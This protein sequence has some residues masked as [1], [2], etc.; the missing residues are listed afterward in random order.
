MLPP[1]PPP[2][3]FRA[4]IYRPGRNPL[5]FFTDLARQYGDVVYLKLGGERLFVISDP[6][7]I[8]DVLVTRQASFMKG[9]GLERA[10]RLLGQGLLTS[11]GALHRQQRRLLQPAFHRDRIATY[12]ATMTGYADRVQCGWK[13]GQTFDVAREMQRL[14]LLIV[15]KT[16]FDTD[17]EAEAGEVGDAMNGV[18][19]SFWLL[20][21]PFSRAL[22]H[23]PLPRIRRGQRARAKLDAMI[24]R[25]IHDRRAS[26]EDRGDL[27]SML[28]TAQDEEQRGGMSD[29]QVRDEAMTIFLAGHETTANALMWTWYLLSQSPEV[30]A[31]LHQEIDRVIGD[32]LPTLSDIPALPYVE[33]VVTESMRLYPPAWIIGRRALEE[34]QLG[35]YT[36]PTRSIVIMSPFIV[37]RDPRHFPDPECFRPER[38]TPE[39]KAKLAPFAYFPFGGGARRCIGESFAWMELALVLST[40]ARRWRLRLVPGHPIVPHPLVTLRSKYGMKMTATRR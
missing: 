11:E 35:D 37:H 2:S 25:M 12:A 39:F 31:R 19:E 33:Q 32:R 16:L 1:G 29:R 22:E 14:T 40:I 10:K 30:E 15:G 13:D 20:M 34:Y 38:W 28:L 26:G 3:F 5:T 6:I 24:Y 21:L 7:W 8:K 27:L 17:V 9:R 18:L 23:L 4:L 36:I